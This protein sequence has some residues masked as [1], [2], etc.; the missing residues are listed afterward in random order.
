MDNPVDHPLDLGLINYVKH[1]SN[2][3]YVVFRFPDIDRAKSFE[4]ALKKNNIAYEKDQEELKTRIIYLFAIHKNHFKKAEKINYLV[5]AKHKK[6]L[7][8]FKIFRYG[9][10]LF[11]AIV[12]TLAIIGY[13]KQQKK[14]EQVNQS[15]DLSDQNKK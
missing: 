12:L 10:M 9:L 15:L 6:P 8:P 4:E 3:D 2:D 1:P 7:I 11:S 5:E 14:L 13:C